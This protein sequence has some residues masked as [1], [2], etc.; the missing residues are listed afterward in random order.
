MYLYICAVF[1]FTAFAIIHYESLAFFSLKILTR[2]CFTASIKI[3]PKRISCSQIAKFANTAK[4]TSFI[5]FAIV[6][7]FFCYF[8]NFHLQSFIFIGKSFYSVHKPRIIF[9]AQNS[10]SKSPT[11][12][13][14]C[15]APN[16]DLPT[17]S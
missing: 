3:C 4:V 17:Y 7:L 9:T 6:R 1:V 14:Q 8:I 5:A 10:H 11:F 13:L 2:H 15:V 16:L 12:F